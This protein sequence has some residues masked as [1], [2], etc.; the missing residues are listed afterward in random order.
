M[1]V[2]R[3]A[4][5]QTLQ[6]IVRNSPNFSSKFFYFPQVRIKELELTEE[7]LKDCRKDLDNMSNN[8]KYVFL[9]RRKLRIKS[10]S[11]KDK[12]I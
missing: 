9:F 4:G 1:N 6:C 5:F 12:I 3:K 11:I 7:T 10:S 8:Y 2:V